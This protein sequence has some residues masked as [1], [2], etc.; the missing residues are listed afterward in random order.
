MKA[1]AVTPRIK[2]VQIINQAEPQVS[3]PTGVKLR[4]L[5]AGVCGTDKEICAF[6]YGTPPTGSEQLVIGH[7]S[8]G[9]VVEV[10]PKVTRIKIGDLVVPMVRRPCLMITAPPAAQIA[11]TFA[12]RE[13]F[14][15][16]G[17]KKGMGSWLS[18]S[19]MTKST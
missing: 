17:L 1:I 9:E 6:Q 11:R 7:E 13:I 2:D 16:A 19:W 5:E 12:L 10:G 18:S 8:L 4:M 14:K 3:S 15:S